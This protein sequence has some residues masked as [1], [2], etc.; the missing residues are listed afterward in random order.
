M[1]NITTILSVVCL[2]LLVFAGVV[3]E[4]RRRYI[5]ARLDQRF[6]QLTRDAML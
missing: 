4:A 1:I 6:C 3:L 2:A 5:K